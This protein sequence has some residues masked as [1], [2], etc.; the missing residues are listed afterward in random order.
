MK[1]IQALSAQSAERGTVD[2][3]NSN[4]AMTI[5]AYASI[6]MDFAIYAERFSQNLTSHTP[7]SSSGNYAPSMPAKDRFKGALKCVI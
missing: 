7:T 5:Q 3:W 6:I 4:V 1:R 2:C